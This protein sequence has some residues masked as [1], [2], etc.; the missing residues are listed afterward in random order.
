MRNILKEINKVLIGGLTVTIVLMLSFL[1]WLFDPTYPVPIWVLSL[2]III[3]YV[4][5]IIIYA[6]CSSK[7]RVLYE[8][9]Q[10]RSIQRVQNKLILIV[11]KNDLFFQGAYL[12]VTYQADNDEVEIILGTGYV[13]TINA[14]GNMQV[15]FAEIVDDSYVRKLIQG[16]ANHKNNCLA[17]KIKPAIMRMEGIDRADA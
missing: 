10:V 7:K 8:L 5:S 17:V 14:R 11:E 3:F 15:V 9:P 13:E 1:W 2:F 16:L 4:I 12:T 6:V